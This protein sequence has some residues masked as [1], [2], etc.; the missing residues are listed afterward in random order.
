MA[1]YASSGFK[2]LIVSKHRKGNCVSV[3]TTPIVRKPPTVLS[4]MSV[5]FS[6]LTCFCYGLLSNLE[7]D[8][9]VWYT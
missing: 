2:S 8:F 3:P 5:L 7:A 4:R 6:E 9:F 1:K